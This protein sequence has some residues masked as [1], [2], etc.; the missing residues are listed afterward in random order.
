ML[1]AC[2][3]TYINRG[4]TDLQLATMCLDVVVKQL[5]GVVPAHDINGSRLDAEDPPKGHQ[6]RGL[7]CP[8]DQVGNVHQLAQGFPLLCVL[9][10]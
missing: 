5:L 1:Y 6:K 4:M 3:Y 10:A 2:M 7:L 9:A 8:K